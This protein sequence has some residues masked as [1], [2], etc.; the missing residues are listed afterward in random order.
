MGVDSERCFFVCEYR[1]FS[2]KNKR[3]KYV[4]KRKTHMLVRKQN[5]S[6]NPVCDI[7]AVLYRRSKLQF[8]IYFSEHNQ[9]E[10]KYENKSFD[11]CFLI[12]LYF[13]DF[14]YF[15]FNHLNSL[16]QW[17]IHTHLK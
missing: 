7:F 6:F 17:A 15:R 1:V 14:V 10:I 16:Y 12:C 3:K 9:I 4:A 5:R 13:I 2:F 8:C 11:E